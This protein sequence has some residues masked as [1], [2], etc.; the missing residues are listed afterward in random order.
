MNVRQIPTHVV[1]TQ[2]AATPQAATS[3]NVKRDI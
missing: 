1:I 3:V 2:I